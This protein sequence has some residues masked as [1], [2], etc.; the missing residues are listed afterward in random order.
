[1]ILRHRTTLV[2][3]AACVA[4][5]FAAMAIAGSDGSILQ[6]LQTDLIPGQ[7]Q[8]TSYGIPLSYDSLPQFITWWTTL[9]PFVEQ[10]PRYVEALTG[11]VAPCCDDNTAYRCCCEQGGSSCNIIRS[12]KGL[13]AHL[14]RDLDYAAA[15]V[16]ESVLEWFRFARPDYYL[17][18]ELEAR[19]LDPG[20]YGLTTEGSCYRGMC[21]IPIS[22]G[23]CGGMDELI[24][25]RLGAAG[26]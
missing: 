19:G 12:G 14:I 20:I 23:G 2:L 22:D 3:S 13:A 26:D 16:A 4:V 10:D 9:V 18:A 15:Q 5:A 8:E 24:E 6:Q 25:P 1:M 11:L 7:G 17:A 21:G